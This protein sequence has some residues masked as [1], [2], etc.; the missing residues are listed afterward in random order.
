[1]GDNRNHSNDSHY[2]GVL[3]KENIEGKVFLLY[4]PL[5]RIGKLAE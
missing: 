3:D 4:W 1:M 5:D 2:W